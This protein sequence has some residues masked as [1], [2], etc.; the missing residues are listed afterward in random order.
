MTVDRIDSLT[1]KVKDAKEAKV[2]DEKGSHRA[3]Y[4]GKETKKYK[5]ASK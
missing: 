3:P 4:E 5:V 2:K 1:I